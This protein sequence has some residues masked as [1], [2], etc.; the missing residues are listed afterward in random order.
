M[1]IRED[2]AASEADIQ[3]Y[4]PVDKACQILAD[5]EKVSFSEAARWLLNKQ[6]PRD[7]PAFEV[8]SVA[9]TA[10]PGQADD[11]YEVLWSIAAEEDIANEFSFCGCEIFWYEVDYV[12]ALLLHG[13]TSRVENFYATNTSPPLCDS[14]C[15]DQSDIATPVDATDAIERLEAEVSLLRSELAKAKAG[16]P[17]EPQGFTGSLSFL[18]ETAPLRLVSAVQQEFLSLERNYS[19]FDMRPPKEKIVAWIMQQDRSLERPTA[20]AIERVA[21]PFKR[22]KAGSKP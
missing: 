11:A 13:I 9:M 2:L 19:D 21:M 12:N 3:G 4:I 17:A 22:G 18:Y 15:G 5:H 1:G 8:D 14:Q 6:F 10:S 7:M 20:E 16:Q